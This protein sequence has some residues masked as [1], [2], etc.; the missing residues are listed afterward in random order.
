[1]EHRPCLAASG[2]AMIESQQRIRAAKVTAHRQARALARHYNGLAEG[3][4][5]ERECLEAGAGY[6]RCELVSSSKSLQRH[7]P[8]PRGSYPTMRKRPSGRPSTGNSK[9]QWR[10]SSR[11]LAPSNAR[12]LK[13]EPARTKP[14]T[15]S[16]ERRR[17]SCAAGMDFEFPR[18]R[19][20]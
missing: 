1:M 20:R 8:L 19:A 5:A 6:S 7:T 9:T 4:T 17:K 14:R 11:G 13:H 10:G 16:N 3:R 18:A 2:A 12:S 15:F